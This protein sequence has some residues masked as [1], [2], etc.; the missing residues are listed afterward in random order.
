MSELRLW[1]LCLSA[2]GTYEAIEPV[3]TVDGQPVYYS[4]M[5]GEFCML[6]EG[7]N[8]HTFQTWDATYGIWLD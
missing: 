2:E 4:D 8:I 3:R 7:E 5:L 1:G 6:D